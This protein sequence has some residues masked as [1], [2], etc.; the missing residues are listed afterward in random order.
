MNNKPTIILSAIVAIAENRV[1]GQNN[2]LPWHL[3]ADLKHFKAI[4]T[5][6]PILMG[7]RTYESIGKPL[8]H[9]KNIVISRDPRYQAPGCLTVTSLEEALSQLDFKKEKELFIIGGAEI[10]QKYLPVL[11]YLYLTLL[12][13]PFEGNVYFPELNFEEWEEISKEEHLQDEKNAYA[14]TFLKLKRKKSI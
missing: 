12:H 7:R 6:H 8:P 4:T 3:P 14:Y 10:Y 9:R 5:G 1:M 13:H 2:K 11:Q